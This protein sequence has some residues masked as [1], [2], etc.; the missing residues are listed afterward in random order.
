MR[1]Y[2]FKIIYTRSLTPKAWVPIRPL[3]KLISEKFMR[4]KFQKLVTLKPPRYSKGYMRNCGSYSRHIPVRK[5]A[6][7][8]GN[9]LIRNGDECAKAAFKATLRC[10]NDCI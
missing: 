1:N 3:T 4:L 8:Y 7:L 10:A 2:G 6:L 9:I 5:V